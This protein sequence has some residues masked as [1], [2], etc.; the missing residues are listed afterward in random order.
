MRVRRW[1]VRVHAWVTRGVKTAPPPP[2]SLLYVS[3][4]YSAPACPPPAP[5]PGTPSS[6]ELYRTV[7]IGL[8]FALSGVLSLVPV[9]GTPL[10]FCVTW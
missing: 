7:V 6:D 8:L 3:V 4:T 9:I 2:P 5:S 1:I 10:G